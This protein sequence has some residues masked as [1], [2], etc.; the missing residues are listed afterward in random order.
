MDDFKEMCCKILPRAMHEYV[1]INF[2]GHDDN[3]ASRLTNLT[4]KVFMNARSY[5]DLVEEALSEQNKNI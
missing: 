3:F 4:E 2:E 1:H 5:D